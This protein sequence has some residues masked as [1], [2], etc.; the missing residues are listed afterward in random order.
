MSIPRYQTYMKGVLRL[1]ATG[2]WYHNG[3]AFTH[4]KLQDLFFKSIAWNAELGEYV[5]RIGSGEARFDY[6]DAVFFV[7]SITDTSVPWQLHF[8]DG[9][10]EPLNPH[11]ITTNST[12]RL[13]CTRKSG[14]RACFLRSSYQHLVQHITDQQTLRIGSETY[15]IQE[16]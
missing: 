15:P 1:S 11:T 13:Y 7:T 5:I 14:E 10:T 12:H 8:S 3:T 4:K 2:T 9:A 16:E 6:D